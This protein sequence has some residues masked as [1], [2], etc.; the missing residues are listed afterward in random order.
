M[1]KHP[2]HQIDD[3]AQLIFHEA[4]PPSWVRNEHSRDYAKDF[5]VEIGE[6]NGDQTGLNFFVQLKG[7]KTVEFIADGTQVKFSLEM[8]HAEYYADKI[9][10]LPVFLVVV[11]VSKKKGWYHFVQPDLQ[12]DL[13]WRKNKKHV[14]VYLPVG[15]DIIDTPKFREAIERAKQMMRLLHPESI[16]DAVAA[17][18]RRVTVHRKPA[19]VAQL[20]AVWADTLSEWKLRFVLTV[21]SV[22]RASP[23]WNGRWPSW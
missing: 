5:L 13:S 14:T 8:K 3:R 1:N 16:Q 19:K 21:G 22:T 10:D 23:S 12:T 11:D 17:Q 15:N 7:Q 6:S 9:K 2:N 20:R 18:K 4:C